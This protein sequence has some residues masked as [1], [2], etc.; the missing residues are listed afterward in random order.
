MSL[1]VN[2]VYDTKILMVFALIGIIIKVFFGSITEDGSSGPADATIYGFGLVDIS[3]LSIIFITFALASR[4]ANV[5]LGIMQFIKNLVIGAYPSII[6]LVM[7]TW[8][9]VIN[10]TYRKEINKGTVP[11]EYNSF[12]FMSTVLILILLA[13][14]FKITHNEVNNIQDPNASLMKSLPVFQS[15]YCDNIPVFITGT[16]KS[17][18][19][20]RQEI[21]K[22]AVPGT[23][24]VP[25]LV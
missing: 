13:L 4:M 6:M 3:I 19:T 16:S 21:Q 24:P 9:I 20:N 14:L 2:L 8:L 1:S 10:A 17:T 23:V 25:L 5:N 11:S 18:K 12:S 22:F 15:A 7:I